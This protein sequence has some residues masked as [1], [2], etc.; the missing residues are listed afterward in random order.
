MKETAEPQTK[1]HRPSE[2]TGNQLHCLNPKSL[3]KLLIF[4]LYLIGRFPKEQTSCSKLDILSLRPGASWIER[5]VVDASS[6]WTAAFVCSQWK[7]RNWAQE[8]L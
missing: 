5:L 1:K 7:S 3:G 4:H 2:T 6:N 8:A